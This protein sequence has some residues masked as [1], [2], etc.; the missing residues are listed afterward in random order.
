MWW[1]LLVKALF[2]SFAP[3]SL[4][5]GFMSDEE[6]LVDGHAADFEEVPGSGTPAGRA[7]AQ[8]IECSQ[9]L[10]KHCPDLSLALGTTEATVTTSKGQV[11]R[12]SM[13]TLAGG[14]MMLVAAMTSERSVLRQQIKQHKVTLAAICRM[15]GPADSQTGELGYDQEEPEGQECGER[16]AVVARSRKRVTPPT[17]VQ[18]KR[19]KTSH[20]KPRFGYLH[21]SKELLDR[22]FD[23]CST[24]NQDDKILTTMAEQIN[25]VRE[26]GKPLPKAIEAF[27]T[28]YKKAWRK[29]RKNSRIFNEFIECKFPDKMLKKKAN[30]LSLGKKEEVGQEEQAQA[31]GAVGESVQV[32]EEGAVQGAGSEAEEEEAEEGAEEDVGQDEPRGRDARSPSSSSAGSSESDD[33]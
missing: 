7:N 27:P 28:S 22:V 26:S 17:A 20:P 30:L 33:E 31:E 12:Y 29:F 18:A 5:S 10:S 2:A 9:F 6:E 8:M 3:L 11:R 13:Q 25:E 4:L 14:A 15:S 1:G 19:P 23:F 21:Q 24:G 32:A 16:E